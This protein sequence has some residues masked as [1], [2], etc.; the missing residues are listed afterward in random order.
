MI[1]AER[2]WWIGALALLCWLLNLARGPVILLLIWVFP[3][4][5][6]AAYLGRKLRESK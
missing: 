4:L 2:F 3:A 1:W 6:F 5:A